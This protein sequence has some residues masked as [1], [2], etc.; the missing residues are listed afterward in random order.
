VHPEAVALPWLQTRQ[1]AVPHVPV[2][3]GHGDALLG[4]FSVGVV[5]Q[6]QLDGVGHLAEDREV[7]TAAVV[8]GTQGVCRAGPDLHCV[9]SDVTCV[10]D[11]SLGA[12]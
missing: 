1:V 9:P 11:A 12:G 8:G 6:A 10:E 2:D 5:E 4:E 3:L 7:D